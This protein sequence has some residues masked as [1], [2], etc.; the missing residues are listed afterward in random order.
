MTFDNATANVSAVSGGVQ[1]FSFA[2][3][4]N[5]LYVN[6]VVATTAVAFNGV[7]LT[8]L[9]AFTP[10]TAPFGSSCPP[11]AVWGLANPLVG[12]ANITVTTPTTVE[13][14]VASYFNAS[15][16]DASGTNDTHTGASGGMSCS[17][18]S[19]KSG[20]I[21][22]FGRGLGNLGV[23][24]VADGSSTLRTGGVGSASVDSSVIVDLNSS[25]TPGTYSNAIAYPSGNGFLSMICLAVQGSG[26]G[27]MF[28]VF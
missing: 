20:W 9:V 15:L 17:V 27:N 7:A 26:E 4:G 12:T 10:S 3:A 21:L 22:G 16:L 28:L 13:T 11:I 1:T 5:Y 19:T 6:T 2:N 8:Q 18:T 24:F 25:K 14:T 23:Q